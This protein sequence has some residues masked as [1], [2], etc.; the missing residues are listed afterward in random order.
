MSAITVA[1]VA[2]R[3]RCKRPV[4]YRKPAPKR[5]EQS[6]FRIIVEMAYEMDASERVCPEE[7]EEGV[8]WLKKNLPPVKKSV[9]RHLRI[10]EPRS[11]YHHTRDS[12]T[13]GYSPHHFRDE[14]VLLYR[15]FTHSTPL[16]NAVSYHSLKVRLEGD[17]AF[18]IVRGNYWCSAMGRETFGDGVTKETVL[19]L[20]ES[21]SVIERSVVKMLRSINPFP[22]VVFP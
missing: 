5:M 9:A 8:S 1:P 17:E 3:I 12:F 13:M 16:F 11:A 20:S 22:D 21:C 18:L 6:I 10:K 15:Y 19:P 2:P 14:T 7:Y 4:V